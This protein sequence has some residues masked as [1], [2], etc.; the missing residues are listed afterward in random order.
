MAIQTKGFRYHFEYMHNLLFKGMLPVAAMPATE[1][2]TALKLTE[3]GAPLKSL[4]IAPSVT[5][6]QTRTFPASSLTAILLFANA[7]VRPRKNKEDSLYTGNYDVL[8]ES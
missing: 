2:L 7:T 8:V 5:S 4:A 3:I 1:Q 6:T